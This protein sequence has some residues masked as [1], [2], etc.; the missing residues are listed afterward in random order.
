MT[1]LKECERKEPQPILR[2]YPRT[3]LEKL[4]ISSLWART[5]TQVL[6]YIKQEY[7]PLDS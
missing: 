6:S 5:G 1:N 2:H 7:T 3:Y 4:G